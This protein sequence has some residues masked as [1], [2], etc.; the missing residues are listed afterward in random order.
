MNVK[1][2]SSCA[3]QALTHAGQKPA[4]ARVLSPSDSLLLPLLLAIGCRA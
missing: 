3:P 2:A 4:L 1:H